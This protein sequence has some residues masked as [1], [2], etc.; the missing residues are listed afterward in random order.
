VIRPSSGVRPDRQDS[1]F[2]NLISVASQP[3]SAI[4]VH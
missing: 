4:A 2:K 1:S 3:G